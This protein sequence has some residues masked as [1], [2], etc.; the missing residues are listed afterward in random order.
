MVILSS[1][2]GLIIGSFLNV[3]ICRLPARESIG[4]RSR[5]P[6]CRRNLEWFELLPVLSFLILKRKC[7]TCKGAIAW[8]YPLVE[9]ATALLFSVS[10]SFRV[11]EAGSLTLPVALMAVRDW[12]FIATLTV[13]FMTDLTSQLIYDAPLFI[14]GGAVLV[15]GLAAGEP[16]WPTIL[17]GILG[18]SFF[19]LQ[20]LIS[21]GTWIGGG[22]IILGGFLGLTLGFPLILVNLALAYV[23]GLSVAL[24]LIASSK[25]QWRSRIAFGTFLSLTG[26][27]TLVWGNQILDWYLQLIFT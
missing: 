14:A 12:C 27:V 3:V 6:H 13:T 2:V 18:A 21:K 9:L 26:I 23:A 22:D 11:A 17:G 16:L 10:L 1:M 20:Y 7:R 19:G 24:P 5:C 15:L 25:K 8:Q 4:G